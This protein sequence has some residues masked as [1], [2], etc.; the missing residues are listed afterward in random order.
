MCSQIKVLVTGASGFIGS[1]LVE[2]CDKSM[3]EFILIS[4]KNIDVEDIDFE[5][6]DSVIHLAGLAEKKNRTSEADIIRVNTDLTCKLAQAAKQGSVKHFIFMSSVKACGN[7]LNVIDENT[8][9]SSENDI[10]GRSKLLAEE[11]LVELS[12][13]DFCVSILRPPIVYG[14]NVKGN[15]L[16]LLKL[17]DSDYLLPFGSIDNKRSMVFIDNLIDFIFKLL[18]K[19]LNGVLL[20]SD[21]NSASTTYLITTIRMYLGRKSR[22]LK[23]PVIFLLVLRKVSPSIYNRLFE[24][25]EVNSEC[26]FNEIEFTPKYSF[27][28]GMRITVDWYKSLSIDEK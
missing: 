24:S 14:P 12:D 1:R 9:C 27:E 28:E 18:K 26:S 3:F 21:P 19:P 5:G 22:L 23:M 15:I 17:S 6:V 13:S 4:L 8:Q 20:V 25:L 10:Y 2:L 7:G 11:N 16:R